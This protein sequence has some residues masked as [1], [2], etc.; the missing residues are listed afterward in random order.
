VR[1]DRLAWQRVGMVP[2]S[3]D[4]FIRCSD[5]HVRWGVFGAAGALFVHVPDPA[6]GDEPDVLLQLRSPFSHEGGTWSCP[7][8]ALDAGETPFAGALRE[9]VEEIGPVPE[10]HHVVGEHRFAPA[11]EWSYTTVVVAVPRRFGQPL[12]FETDAVEWVPASEVTTRPLHAGFRAAWPHL[13]P[14]VRVAAA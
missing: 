10:P 14:I 2:R 13:L 11:D 9:A 8:G 4:G 7:G 12:N 1:H 5:G 3:G 6:D